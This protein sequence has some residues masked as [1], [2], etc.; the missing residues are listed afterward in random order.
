MKNEYQLA[1]VEAAEAALEAEEAYKAATAELLTMPRRGRRSKRHNSNQ[2][3]N[4]VG[5][6]KKEQFTS[7]HEEMLNK[8]HKK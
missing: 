4:K 8:L 6:P 5:R 2:Q 1:E 7:K 3:K